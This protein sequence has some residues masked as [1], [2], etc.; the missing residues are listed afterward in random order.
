LVL[1]GVEGRFAKAPTGA[2]ETATSRFYSQRLSGDFASL[3]F[4][5]A[6]RSAE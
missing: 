2:A 4:A 1:S 3:K 5:P 6:G